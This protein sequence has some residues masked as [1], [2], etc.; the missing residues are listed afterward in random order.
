MSYNPDKHHRR[1]IRLSG[2]DYSQAGYYFVT[3]CCYQRQCFFGEIIDGAMQLNQYGEIVAETYQWLAQRYP[4]LILDEWVIMP[5]HFHGIMVL[6]NK[7][8]G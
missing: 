6:T 2:Y 5:N 7:P 8:S 1:S 4:Y 3:I